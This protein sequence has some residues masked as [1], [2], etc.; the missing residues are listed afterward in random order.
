M[1]VIGECR[2]GILAVINQCAK[3]IKFQLGYIMQLQLMHMYVTTQAIAAR[4]KHCTLTLST[5]HYDE[6]E[7]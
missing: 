2:L 1:Q 5:N 6:C 7:I 4:A 3:H